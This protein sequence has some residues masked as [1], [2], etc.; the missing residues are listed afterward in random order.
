MDQFL[1]KIKRPLLAK[2]NIGYFDGELKKLVL[3]RNGQS[4]LLPVTN[5]FKPL[6][7]I[8]ARSFYQEKLVTYPLT[9]KKELNKLLALETAQ[10]AT[11]NAINLI[12]G[13]QSWVNKWQFDTTLPKA[14]VVLPESLVLSA[15][16]GGLTDI[17]VS[18][19]D[20]RIQLFVANSA[21]GLYSAKMSRL[22]ASRLLFCQSSGL[23]YDQQFDQVK[24]AELA[25]VLALGLTRLSLKS[26]QTFSHLAIAPTDLKTLLKPAL[27]AGALG[28]VYIALTSAY[29][30]F[31]QWQVE[32]QLSQDS[33]ELR[34]ALRLETK[35]N[36]LRDKLNMY[37]SVTQNFAVTSHIWALLLPLFE[38]AKFSQVQLDNKRYILSG[39]ADKAT[40]IL[41]VLTNTSNVRDAKFDLPVSKIRS[42]ERFTVS[43]VLL[44][45]KSQAQV[46]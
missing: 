39:E 23:P 37:Q 17:E 30:G 33:D 32:K 21:R 9:N 16:N 8:V 20:G 22:L 12:D 19:Q 44:D 5:T 6:I 13:N 14:R 40:D 3:N 25:G 1:D 42:K 28:I 34:Q 11:V 2:M 18:H 4:T 10:T 27:T 38:L 26:W 7:L 45:T 41:S 24:Q 15:S 43:F 46:Q 36:V 29:I 31:S 35:N